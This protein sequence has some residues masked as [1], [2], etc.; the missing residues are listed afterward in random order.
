MDSIYGMVRFDGQL[1]DPNEIRTIVNRAERS[2]QDSRID[3]ASSHDSAWYGK[4]EALGF[5]P[6]GGKLDHGPEREPWQH[7]ESGC[8]ITAQARIDNR[9]ELAA[10]LGAEGEQARSLPDYQLI[11]LAY[12]RWGVDCPRR[13]LGEFAFAIW[14]ETQQ[15][16]FCARDPL[17]SGSIT[18]VHAQN[19]FAFASKT[20]WLLGLPGVSAQPNALRIADFLVP[21]LGVAPDRRTWREGVLWL[22]HGEYL[23]LGPGN[24][25]RVSQWWKPSPV[26]TL[27]YASFEESKEH[28]LAVFQQAVHCRLFAEDRPAAL[29]MSGGIDSMAIAAAMHQ[30]LTSDNRLRTYSGIFD[31]VAESLESQSIL[32]LVDT[33]G[34]NASL[35]SVPSLA[36]SLS[37]ND[38][39]Q[40]AWSRPHPVENSLLVPSMACL[41]ASRA[42]ESTMLHGASGDI[43]SGAPIFYIASLIRSGNWRLGW[44]ESQAASKNNVYLRRRNP[45]WMFGRAAAGVLAPAA[46][47]RLV[48]RLRRTVQDWIGGAHPAELEL[49]NKDLLRKILHAQSRELNAPLSEQAFKGPLPSAMNFEE[50][51]SGQSGFGLIGRR[52]GIK[53]SDPWSDLRVV[54]F[55]RSLPI[56]NKVRDGWT[57][58]LVR[59][60]YH[61]SVSPTVLWRKD[62]EHVGWRFT[63]QVMRQ[64]GPFIA[65][66]FDGELERVAEYVD[67]PTARKLLQK[68]DPDSADATLQTVFDLMTLILWTRE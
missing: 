48:R 16:L 14:D 26:E 5:L 57:K 45:Y 43:V 25:L 56:K 4:H 38:L 3:G 8:V 15:I 41:A 53:L 54:Q 13:L 67:V 42:G 22:L 27:S 36:G 10:A 11:L 7:K 68:Y 59:S 6:S 31:G 2:F 18:Y 29:M 51:G 47:K 64:S 61:K 50:L 60:A 39:M 44:D 9:L 23:I 62:K 66:V 58:S 1:I 65:D 24:S 33:F 20:E 32:S 37:I 17:G 19:Y 12:L 40:V 35:I 21:A 46:A 55:F 52:F 63:Q 49:L 34:C 28:F 30:S